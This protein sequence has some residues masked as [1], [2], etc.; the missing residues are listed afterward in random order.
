[1]TSPKAAHK[2]AS[3]KYGEAASQTAKAAANTT[4]AAVKAKK[5][6]APAAASTANP[7]RAKAQAAVEKEL[8]AGTRE[9]WKNEP[10]VHDYPA[11]DSFLRL[12]MNPASAKKTVEALKKADVE[13]HP[14]KDI[15]RA[16]SLE[17]LPADDPAV[18]RDLD[19]VIAGEQLSPVLLVRGHHSTGVR[20]TI[21]DGYHRVCASYHL[22]ENELIP[23]RIS[24]AHFAKEH[25][26]KK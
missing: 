14:V 4:S 10:D 23:C 7:S 21:A 17:L 2:N 18:K 19:K 3:E 8:E 11:A 24:E 20:L 5:T 22:G 15:L 12:L 1:M 13:K 26:G 25:K 16:S 6:S 9:L